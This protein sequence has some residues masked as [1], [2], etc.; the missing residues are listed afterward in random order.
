MIFAEELEEMEKAKKNKKIDMENKNK[1]NSKELVGRL[2]GESLRAF[3]IRLNQEKRAIILEELRKAR[4]VSERKLR[5][6]AKRKEAKEERK[7]RILEENEEKKEIIRKHT[8]KGIVTPA[9]RPPQLKQ[10]VERMIKSDK[11][12]RSEEEKLKR[13][14]KIDREQALM[15]CRQN[16]DRFD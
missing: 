9:D 12:F 14:T 5:Y 3:H 1:Y 7:K 11:M 2:P 4:P 10:L 8:N 6:A 13:A 15:Q 16:M